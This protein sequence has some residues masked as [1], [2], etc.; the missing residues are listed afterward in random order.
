[1]RWQCAAKG[2]LSS[3]PILSATAPPVVLSSRHALLESWDGNGIW[4]NDHHGHGEKRHLQVQQDSGSPCSSVKTNSVCD[5]Q[6]RLQVLFL[7]YLAVFSYF[8]IPK[9]LQDFPSHQIF[10]RMYEAL[11][12]GKK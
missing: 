5:R 7:E 8:K 10:R 6:F 3:L 12:V 4:Q 9:I 2:W 1:M 11:N